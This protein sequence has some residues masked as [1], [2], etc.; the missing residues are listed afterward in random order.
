MY[1]ARRRGRAD[2][3][4]A[5]SVADRLRPVVTSFLGGEP[6]IAF[7]FWDGS[8]LGSPDD[9]SAVTLRSPRALTRLLYAPG[10]LGFARGYVGDDLDI[11]GDIFEVLG[12][13]DMLAKRTQHTD[14]RL[15]ARA[16]VLLLR[17]ALGLG[18]LGLPPPAPP[19]EIQLRGRLHSKRRDA[20]AISHH[21][22]V[23]NDFYRLVLGDTM[24]YS[25]AFFERDDMTLD[26]AQTAKYDLVCRKLGLKPG[27]RLLD[28]GCGWGGMVLHAVRHYGVSAVG[29]TLSRA[30]ADLAARRVAESGV[31]HLVDI[32]CQD[33]R[34]VRDG[35][36]DAISSIGMFEHV[37][38]AQLAEYFSV[39]ESF[40]VPRGRLLNHAISK[41]SGEPGFDARSFVSRYVF[42][43]GELQEVGGV[44]SAMQRLG[45][46]ARDVESLRE[47]YALTLRS[48]VRNLESNW[49]EAV[50][51]V[52]LGRAKV[53]RLYMAGSALG[54]E[55]SRINLHQVLGV[56]PDARGG[57]GMPRTRVSFVGDGQRQL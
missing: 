30:Q 34:E 48:W 35:P 49:T 50:D 51:L 24:T 1:G 41:P 7:R 42:P 11:E 9:R 36:F 55:A 29:I 53:W 52:G 56:K 32:R 43:D 33:Y 27:M 19:E 4:S 17:A 3:A 37:G 40:L 45:L 14:L 38:L 28:V 21:Y 47:H 39:L 23:G 57:A 26:E 12:L 13:R 2:D 31:G 25:C 54:F 18:A 16:G 6:P 44:V 46:E 15:D 22:D 10:E 5:V 20:A 8:S